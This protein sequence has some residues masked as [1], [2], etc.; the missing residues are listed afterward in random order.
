MVGPLATS[1]FSTDGVAVLAAS[2]CDNDGI[3]VGCTGEEEE[4]SILG[5]LVG[6]FVGLVGVRVLVQEGCSVT[7]GD[8]DPVG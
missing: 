5:T 1:V 2:Y 6:M 4:G 7:V 3:N 8:A